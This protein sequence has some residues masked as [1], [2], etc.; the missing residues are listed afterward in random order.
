M[1]KT[2]IRL[3]HEFD[4]KI[5]QNVISQTYKENNY[6]LEVT[7]A[8]LYQLSQELNISSVSELDEKV[9]YLALLFKD[10]PFPD[11]VDINLFG[12]VIKLCKFDAEKAVAEIVKL[13]DIDLRKSPLGGKVF[14]S[15]DL[16]IDDIKRE[17]LSNEEFDRII[18]SWSSSRD[19]TSTLCNASTRRCDVPSQALLSKLREMFSLDQVET[20]VLSEILVHFEND[21]EKSIDHLCTYHSSIESFSQCSSAWKTSSVSYAAIVARAPSSSSTEK[22][23]PLAVQNIRDQGAI[24]ASFR[25]KTGCDGGISNASLLHHASNPREGN[26]SRD[27][28]NTLTPEAI[29]KSLQYWT[30]LVDDLMASLSGSKSRIGDAGAL[31]GTYKSYYLKQKAVQLYRDEVADTLQEIRQAN[32]YCALY[33]L[34][35]AHWDLVKLAFTDEQ[36][37]ANGT[38]CPRLVGFSDYNDVKLDFHGFKVIHATLALNLILERLLSREVQLELRRA[39]GRRVVVKLVVGRGAHSRQGKAKLRP[40]FEGILKK[41]SR[42]SYDVLDGELV[43]SFK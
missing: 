14:V 8:I 16:L 38:P 29:N 41:E 42:V 15:S 32:T 20:S 39:G 35:L 43:V 31:S 25:Y 6:Q 9:K 24:A 11:G 7:L 22:K 30:Q 19:M 23:V 13:Y 37:S 1:L 34:K 2:V 4:C 3:Y 28:G 40:A 10:H 26:Y 27:F 5:D 36:L 12:D 21:I 33:Q 17:D 18:D